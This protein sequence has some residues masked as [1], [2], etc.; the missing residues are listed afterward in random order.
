MSNLSNKAESYLEEIKNSFFWRWIVNY[1]VSFLLIILVILYGLYVAFTIPK[2][3]SPDIKFGIVS[4]TTVYPGA[5]PVDIDDVITTKIEDKIKDLDGI[6][7]I[8]SSSSLWVSS[9]TI[10]LDNGVDVTDF[11]ND[12]RSNIDTISFPDDVRDPSVMEIST[13]NEVLFQMILYGP[14]KDFS[15]NHLRS[16]AMRFKDDIKGK[17]WIVDV[18]VDASMG[19]GRGW[20]LWWSAGSDSDFDMQIQLD[21]SKLEWYGLTMGQI[22]WQI[23]AY[24][25][26]LPLGNYKLWDLRYDYRID[27]ELNSLADL[28]NIPIAIAGGYIRLSE[29]SKIIR[30]YK[31]KT[32]TYGG[33]YDSAENHAIFLVIY[34]KNRSNVFED[35]N[36]ARAIIDDT[37][38]KLPYKGLYTAYT[39]DLADVIIDD[40]T[41][42]W[43]NGVTSVLLVFLITMI[44]IWLRQSLIATL[45]MPI[46]FFIT[47]MVLN[48]LG[49]TMN[50]MVNFS[51]ILSFGMGI[52]T[53]LVFI[54]SARENMKKWYNP[55]SAILITMHTYARPNII[56]SLINI[57]VFIPMLVLPGIVG[58]FLS[59]IPITLFATLLASLFLA[60]TVNGA[61]F[62]R[63]NKK[64]DYYY[65]DD[66]H[67]ESLLIMSAEEKEILFHEREGKTS[68]PV[69]DAPW[70]EQKID[71]LREYYVSTLRFLL[72]H[73][74]WRR[75][76]IILPVWLVFATLLVLAPSIWFKL[77]PS[78]DNPS[79]NF[80]LTA[81]EWTDVSKMAEIVSG[82][83]VFISKIPELKSYTI[84][85]NNTKVNIWIEL[86]KKEERDRDGF[87][88][89]AQV[90][91][92]LSYLK[93]QWYKF[94][95]K[96]QAWW[97]PTGKA[98]G[99][100]LVA[101]DKKLLTDL[102]KVSQDFENYLAW[103]TWAINITNSSTNSPWQFSFIFDSDKL[104]QYGLTPS[105]LQSE[106]YSA[107]NGIKAGTMMVDTKE[108]DIIL[109][110]DTF[111]DDVSPETLYN[112]V[113]TTKIWQIRLSDVAT[114]STDPSLTS[115]KRVD[116]DIVISVE[117]D[118]EQWLQPTN[119]QPK[120]EEFAKSY[121]YPTGISYK[122]WWENEANADLI[123]WAMIAFVVALFMTFVLL[124]YM[125]NSFSKPAIV[126][127]SIFTALL[128]VNIGLRV[129]G[130]PYSMAFAIWFIS[131]IWVIVN[132]A[133]FL[134]D[135]INENQ[136]KWVWLIESIIESGQARFKPIIISTLTTIL[137]LA[138]SVT[139]D[140]FYAWLGYTVIFGLVF[141]SVITLVAVPVLY[142][143]VFRDKE[144]GELSRRKKLW[145]RIVQ[146]ATHAKQFIQD[147][148]GA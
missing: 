103:L 47:F 79:M 27:N 66:E 131:L 82:V 32:I 11:I 91:S 121:A 147:R 139:Q 23:R 20:A 65:N 17:W 42:L 105:D 125:F 102:K 110:L 93:T 78:G 53:V 5:N 71:N 114:V 68:I 33:I 138:S 4:V 89:Q 73:S 98:V 69:T 117:A 106:I 148:R 25:Q 143:T 115:V 134:V 104:A 96:V 45:A 58:K 88:I 116:N 62:A 18:W 90:E 130:N 15:M 21:Q 111:I 97:P 39:T 60:L 77:F 49:M 112:L 86:V 133:I 83:D 94:E 137:W 99:I 109:K 24:N 44:F 123:Q 119:F 118:L 30:S 128:W 87:T 132:T 140:E 6:D 7:K 81:R 61:L 9:V 75:V 16:L 38:Q 29:L 72:V 57:V 124:V 12:V 67:D 108:R 141:S 122:S 107:I 2:E 100:K 70:L 46:S 80:E 40:Y 74:F 95:G 36:T 3:S 13:A 43:W 22:V 52:D 127:Y 146:K 56:T 113:V 34:K 135:R 84:G 51:L 35:S 54:E 41:S 85:V 37:L 59:F 55:M 129:T 28:Q 76:T 63:F 8:E 101:N 1:K 10:T 26:N 48:Y 92:G 50:F 126:L 136:K 19:G 142:Y 145:N 64:L 120:L 31:N 14:K 144:E